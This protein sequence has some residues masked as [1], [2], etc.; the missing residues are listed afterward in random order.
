[1]NKLRLSFLLPLLA[2]AVLALFGAVALYSTLS[3]SRDPAQLPSV[4]VGKPA[5]KTTLQRLMQGD[6]NNENSVT[7]TEFRGQPLLV[8]FF[9]SWC[10]PC[11]AEAPALEMLLKDI[12]IF[13]IAYK[14]RSE[15]TAEFLRQ[16]GNPFK[17]IGM[18]IDGRTGIRWGV[19]GVPET[20]LLDADGINFLM[21]YFSRLNLIET[22]TS[23]SSSVKSELT[24]TPLFA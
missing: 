4:L 6:H 9:A 13:G 18:D 19:Y 23:L 12:A 20:Y 14:D 7:M 5:P 1:M 17:V 10:A 21:Q 8:N 22:T 11:R 16:F 2:F 15:D 3:G 24:R